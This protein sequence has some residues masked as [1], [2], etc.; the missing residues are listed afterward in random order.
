M[1]YD[2]FLPFLIIFSIFSIIIILARKIPHIS[3]DENVVS[4][5][6]DKKEPKPHRLTALFCFALSSSEKI[7]RQ[8]RIHI[9]KFDAKIFSLI[10]YLR[11]ESAKKLE[12]VNS[13][14]HKNIAK[15]A[16]KNKADKISR[17]LQF[18]IEERKLLHIIARNP[19]VAE[20]YKKLGLLYFQ[21]ENFTDAEASFSEYLKINPVDAETRE[22]M[23]KMGLKKE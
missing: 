18:K 14:A 8:V 17:K 4:E 13:L 21:N 1:I 22:L 16:V 9:L 7:L 12:E 11:K 19:K 10:E 6:A 2:V 3:L 20:N 5:T 15:T 23:E